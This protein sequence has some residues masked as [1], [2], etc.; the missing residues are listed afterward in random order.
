MP[1]IKAEGRAQMSEPIERLLSCIETKGDLNFAICE[2]VGRVILSKDKLNYTNISECIDAV[3]DAE[4]EL[5][6][7]ILEPYEDLK[8]DE[9]ADLLSFNLIL[10]KME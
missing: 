4:T 2:L 3:H 7:R 10:S 9:S 5:R 6:R 1:Y 8:I